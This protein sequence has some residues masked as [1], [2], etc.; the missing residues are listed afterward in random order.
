MIQA[1]G[2]AFVNIKHYPFRLQNSFTALKLSE[3]KNEIRGMY[4]QIYKR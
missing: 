3:I 2:G 4:R 1:R